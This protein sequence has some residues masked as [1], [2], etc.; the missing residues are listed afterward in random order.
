MDLVGNVVA[1][2]G[3]G[4]AE[5]L[6][7]TEEGEVGGDVRV[8]GVKAEGEFL[9]FEPAAGVE[10]AEGPG[11][12]VAPVGDAA[13]LGEEKVSVKLWGGGAE[14]VAHQFS[15]RDVSNGYSGGGSMRKS[16]PCV[17]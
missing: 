17:D 10:A 15:G 11:E 12:K 5:E 7:A 3:H 13:E 16:S 2:G 4:F 1:E 6:V 9:E 14:D 8:G